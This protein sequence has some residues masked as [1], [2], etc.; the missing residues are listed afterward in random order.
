MP[1]L[2]IA[3]GCLDAMLIGRDF[4]LR[5]L[6]LSKRFFP[7]FA[8]GRSLRFEQPAFLFQLLQR[9]RRALLVADVGGRAQ[10][11][12]GRGRVSSKRDG[13]RFHRAPRP[14][15][16]RQFVLEASH[17]A[18]ADV[19]DELNESL[20]IL[21]RNE[22][23]ERLA[24]QVVEPLDAEQ[25]QRRPVG[26]QNFALGIS[27]QEAH[28]RRLDDELQTALWGARRGGRVGRTRGRLGRAAGCFRCARSTRHGHNRL[29]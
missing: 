14:V 20:A 24:D 17:F 7:R 4:V 28:G 12:R 19:S 2:G 9:R 23:I 22:S 25:R 29:C 16:R 3:Q 26:C 15:G 8:L 18:A 13:V 10:E 1:R 11:G 21:R 5:A 27:D 6:G